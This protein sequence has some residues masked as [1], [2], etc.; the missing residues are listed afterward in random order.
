MIEIFPNLYV[1]TERDANGVLDRADQPRDPWYVIS[2]AKEP[3]HRRA[4]GYTTPGAPKTHFEYLMALRPNHM[5][6]NLVDVADPAY[7]RDE[8]VNGTMLVIHEMLGPN[9]KI[10]IHCNQG[11]SRS[12]TLGML[13]LRHYTDKLPQDDYDEGVAFFRGAI[14]PAYAPA[15]G[16]ADYAR[17]HWSDK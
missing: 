2:A 6:L 9:R 14:Y 12:P 15:K 1:G 8:I 11:L 17:Q 5:I 16:M 4:V 10:L 13:Y 7:I 3:W